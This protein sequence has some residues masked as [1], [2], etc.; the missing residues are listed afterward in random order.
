M[1]DCLKAKKEELAASI[2]KV[3]D[4]YDRGCAGINQ[5]AMFNKAIERLREAAK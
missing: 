3:L 5:P 1:E 2:A 4:L